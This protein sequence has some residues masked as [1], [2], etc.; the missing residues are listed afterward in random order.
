MDDFKVTNWDEFTSKYNK[1]PKRQGHFLAPKWPFFMLVVGGTGSGKSN[2]ALDLMFKYLYYD[3]VYMYVKKPNE[4]KMDF[5]REYYANICEVKNREGRKNGTKKDYKLDDILFIGGVDDIKDPSEYNPEY[6]NLIVFDDMVVEKH[7]ERIAETFIRGR[8]SN[9]SCIYMTQSFAD[10]PGA[11]RKQCNYIV[12]FKLANETA[13]LV[14]RYYCGDI[15]KDM[16]MNIFHEATKR[17]HDFLM[18]ASDEY[19][20]VLKFRRN[21]NE[22]LDPHN[23]KAL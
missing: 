23:P 17:K 9:C 10:V 15:D 4:D 20:P 2:V 3:R 6:Q 19:N 11:I 18:I 14:R 22:F 16:F 21:W 5:V 12:L 7:Q 8:G 13:N 1:L